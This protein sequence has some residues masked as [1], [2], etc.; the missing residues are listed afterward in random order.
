M[1][2]I[3]HLK[4]EVEER[5]RLQVWITGL[6]GSLVCTSAFKFSTV[7]INMTSEKNVLNLRTGEKLRHVY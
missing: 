2:Q 5:S 7:T 1:I 4:S 3:E 6:Y